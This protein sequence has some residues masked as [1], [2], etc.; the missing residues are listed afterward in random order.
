MSAVMPISTRAL[1]IITMVLLIAVAV[2]ADRRL[3]GDPAAAAD[4]GRGAVGVS[5]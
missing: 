2:A 4:P 3:V 1:M 5:A